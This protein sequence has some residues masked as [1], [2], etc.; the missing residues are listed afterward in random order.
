MHTKIV[1]QHTPSEKLR[2]RRRSCSAVT[3]PRGFT[4]GLKRHS[5]LLLLYTFTATVQYCGVALKSYLR[6]F[7][8]IGCRQE[9]GEQIIQTRAQTVDVHPYAV[10]NSIICQSEYCIQLYCI[11][12]NCT[13]LYCCTLVQCSRVQYSIFPGK[14]GALCVAFLGF[15]CLML[16]NF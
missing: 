4:R 13:L 10:P 15:V 14:A 1:L 7:S 8:T 5:Q 11:V 16:Q 3:A 2:C 9:S 6:Q 12:L